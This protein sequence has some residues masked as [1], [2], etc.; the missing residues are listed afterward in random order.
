M[1]YGRR[2]AACGIVE[3]SSVLQ[4]VAK[5]LHMEGRGEYKT[6]GGFVEKCEEAKHYLYYSQMRGR[7][8][9]TFYGCA[10]GL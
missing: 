7:L 3:Q 10:Q 1:P 8:A 2:T 6:I 9:A 4:D 5:A